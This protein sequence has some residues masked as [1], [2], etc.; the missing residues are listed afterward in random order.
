MVSSTD[1]WTNHMVANRN[2]KTAQE[3]LDFFHWRN[4]QYPGYIEL[5]PVKGQDGK[6][7]LDYGCGPG[8]DLVGFGEF[9]H[10]EK[11]YG[12]DVSKTALKASKERL[13]L[14]GIRAELVH[15]EESANEIPFP[16]NSIDYI[17]TSGV[18]H[19]CKNLDAILKEFH[20]IL[21]PDGK[22]SI[23][24]YNYNS[25]WLHLF[26]AYVLQIQ[27]NKLSEYS[28]LEA[29]RHSTDGEGC[30]ISNCYTKEQFIDIMNQYSFKGNLKGCY[31]SSYELSFVERATAA[32]SHPDLD[33]EHVE[34][35]KALTFNDQNFPLYNGDIAG[36]GGCYTFSK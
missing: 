22:I 18:L 17:H 25:I 34:F 20:R 4:S 30:P 9:S 16:A 33:V 29:F 13:D 26:V 32:Q 19:H 24:V 5:M 3:S 36:I 23:M 8:N 27:K 14:H 2:H 11:L 6:T 21:K 35:L 28:I 1:Y 15:V 7:V 31:I 12:L 10:P